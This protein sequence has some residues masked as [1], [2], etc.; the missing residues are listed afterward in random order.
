MCGIHSRWTIQL[1]RADWK[2]VKIG[3]GPA[4]VIGSDDEPKVRNVPVPVEADTL[5]ERGCGHE[6]RSVREAFLLPEFGGR[7]AIA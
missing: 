5:R 2:A 6:P 7:I 3:H 1:A 4:T